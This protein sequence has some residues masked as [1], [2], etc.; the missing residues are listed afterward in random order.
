M[1]VGKMD[2]RITIQQNSGVI[3]SLTGEQTDA[4]TDVC[5]VWGRRIQNA[6]MQR[7]QG[8]QPISVG[9]DLWFIRFRSDVT[10]AMRVVYDSVNYEI[11]SIQE[12]GRK[13]SLKLMVQRLS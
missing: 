4:W 2:R 1:V 8:E 12:I 5:E 6:G 10:E 7:M 11:L 13:D 3:D 9:T